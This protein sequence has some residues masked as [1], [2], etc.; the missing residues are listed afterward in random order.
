MYN[1]RD[2]TQYRYATSPVQ[3]RE[4]TSCDC[5]G[6]R[7]AICS[8]PTP[9]PAVTPVAMAFVPFQQTPEVYD[10]MKAFCRGTLFPDLDKP[11]EG[12]R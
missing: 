8:V 10:D 4:R 9:F 11:F 5:V 2:N 12:C 3:G 7:C 1:S 6:S